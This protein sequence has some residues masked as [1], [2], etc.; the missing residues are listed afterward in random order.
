MTDQTI[1][2]VPL[3]SPADA[4]AKVAA[5]AL[6]VDV[7]SEGARVKFGTV[8]G[9]EIVA[10]DAVAHRFSGA[11]GELDQ[12]IVVFCGSPLGSGPVTEELS[13]IGYTNVSHVDGGFPAWQEAGLPVDPGTGEV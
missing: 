4:Q 10:K 12:E 11:V 8:P 6:L 7:R 5:G 13:A 9:A 2:A 1:S 3:I